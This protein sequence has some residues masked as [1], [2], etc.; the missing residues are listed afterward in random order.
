MTKSLDPEPWR[1][2]PAA[3]RRPDRG[4][5]RRR[6]TGEI[7]DDDRPRGARVRA[8]ARGPLRPRH[9]HSAS[10]RR[11]RQFV[12]VIR[13]PDAGRGAGREVYLAARPRRAAPGADARL[14][15]G[16]LPGRR[17]G[18]LAPLRRRRPPRRLSAEPLSLLAE[19]IFAY[20]DELSADSVDGFAEAQAEVEDLRRRRRRE[21]TRLLV[22]DEPADRRR[23]RGRRRGRPLDGCRR[24]SRR[25]PAPRATSTRSPAGC[26][27]TRWRRSSTAA[28]ACS[29]PTPRARAGSTPL[30]RLDGA[31]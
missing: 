22:G 10:P 11:S 15:A 28:A 24:G 4:R 13:D 20:I 14:A 7:L 23:A 19:S 6:S 21:L 5:D 29:S 8:A 12:A 16:G 18:R 31:A 2:L 1:G 3:G 9:P 17:P 25:S 27:R 26:R 30:R